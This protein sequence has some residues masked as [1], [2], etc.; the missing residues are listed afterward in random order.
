MYVGNKIN[1]ADWDIVTKYN[2]E[3]IEKAKD[4]SY[5]EVVEVNSLT[6]KVSRWGKSNVTND[7]V[8]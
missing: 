5:I 6:N 8:R 3:F 7:G 1:P 4:G 2:K